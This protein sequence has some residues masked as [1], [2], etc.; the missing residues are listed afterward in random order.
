MVFRTALTTAT[1]RSRSAQETHK[2]QQTIKREDLHDAK[3]IS[4]HAP[5]AS[6]F[7]APMCATEFEIVRMSPMKHLH[8]ANHYREI[9]Y[10][11]LKIRLTVVY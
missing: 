2:I 7:L 9:F 5:T 1:K 8:Y 10:I 11:C 3:R 4:L 6:A